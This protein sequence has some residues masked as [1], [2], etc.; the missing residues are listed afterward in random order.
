MVRSKS[1]SWTQRS[2]LSTRHQSIQIEIFVHQ[3][4][5]FKARSK[6]RGLFATHEC[7]PVAIKTPTAKTDYLYA[8]GETYARALHFKTQQSHVV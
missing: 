7:K 6:R 2:E 5:Q 3:F 1:T 8:Y 4:K